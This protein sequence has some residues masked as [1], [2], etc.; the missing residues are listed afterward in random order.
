[1]LY[2]DLFLIINC[3]SSEPTQ[4]PVTLQDVENFINK[5][6]KD[7]QTLSA[8]LA[9][10]IHTKEGLEQLIECLNKELMNDKNIECIHPAIVK[11][12]DNLVRWVEHST[13]VKYKS[14]N[15]K[16]IQTS[17]PLY[18]I[19]PNSQLNQENQLEENYS[20]T[21]LFYSYLRIFFKN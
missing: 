12:D 7:N 3:F 16:I 13:C 19:N 1:M 9:P 18:H 11:P 8:L 6:I 21:T 5:V 4:Q 17:L 10:S 15:D 2:F 20:R 14:Y